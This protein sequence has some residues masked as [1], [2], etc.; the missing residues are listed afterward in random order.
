MDFK[1]TG[2]VSGAK[3]QEQTFAPSAAQHDRRQQLGI[4]L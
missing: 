1:E 2:Q 4:G 3:I